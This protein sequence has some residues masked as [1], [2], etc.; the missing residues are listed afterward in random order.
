MNGQRVNRTSMRRVP[1]KRCLILSSDDSTGNQI[2]SMLKGYGWQIH[3]VHSDKQAYERMQKEP[4]DVVIADIDAINLGGLAVLTYCHHQDQSLRI[5][6][7]AP[8]DDGYRKKIAR[9]LAGCAGFFYLV[10]GSLDIDT[11]RG[12]AAR[13]ERH[14]EK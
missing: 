4:L 11:C 8:R 12:M 13:L 14:P 7:I 5:Y 3:V 9:D 6:A 2:A 10:N 1:P